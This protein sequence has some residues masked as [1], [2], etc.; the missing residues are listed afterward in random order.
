MSTGTFP[1]DRRVA[2]YHVLRSVNGGDAAVLRWRPAGRSNDADWSG[3][4]PRMLEPYRW[5]PYDLWANGWRYEKPVF[6]LVSEDTLQAEV[7]ALRAAIQ[8]AIDIIDLNRAEPGPNGRSPALYAMAQL[9]LA[10][11]QGDSK[12]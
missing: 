8:G 3:T 1:D 12:P 4:L 9:R 2:G 11:C 10:I 5:S 6:S 7:A